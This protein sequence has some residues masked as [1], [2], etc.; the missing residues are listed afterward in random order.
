VRATSRDGILRSDVKANEVNIGD[1]FHRDVRFVAPLYQRPYVWTHEKNWLPMWDAIRLVADRQGREG[2]RDAQARPYFLGAIV[3]EPLNLPTARVTSWQLIDGQ[4]RLTTLQIALAKWSELCK[5]RGFEDL[6][7]L[8]R[9]LTRNRLLSTQDLGEELKVWPTNRD[10]STYSAI[11]RGEAADV[12]T[13]GQNRLLLEAGEFFK[14]QLRDWL[15]DTEGDERRNFEDLLTAL[16][17]WL[18]LV[19]IRLEP[20]DDPQQIFETLNSLGTPLL[21]ADLVKNLL[22]RGMSDTE[23]EALYEKTWRHFEDKALFWRDRVRQGRL[24]TPRIDLFLQHYLV[25]HLQRDVPATELF[26]EFRRYFESGNKTQAQELRELTEYAEIFERIERM[27]RRQPTSKLGA[28]LRRLHRLDTTTVYPLLLEIF[29]RMSDA[30]PTESVLILESYLVRRAV[31]RLTSKN[32]NRLFVQILRDLAETWTP[33]HLRQLLLGFQDETSRWPSD[34]E[35]VASWI[36]VEAYRTLRSGRLLAIFE[37]LEREARSLKNEEIAVEGELS[38]EHLMPQTWTE[39]AW[40][41]PA[42]LEPNEATARR[43]RLVHNIGNLAVLTGKL[44]SEQ[45][46]HPWSKKRPILLKHSVSVLNNALPPEWSDSLI[47]ARSAELAEL[48]K[49]AWPRPATP[50][51]VEWRAGQPPVGGADEEEE[52]DSRGATYKRFFQRV[53]AEFR[54]V[55]PNAN[56]S[57]G[58][59][60]WSWFSF[61]SAATSESHSRYSWSFAAGKRLRSEL[62]IDAKTKAMAKKI[63]DRLAVKRAEIEDAYGGDLSWERLDA[64]K[65][66]RIADYREGN[67]YDEPGVT[68]ELVDWA[69][70]AMVSLYDAVEPRLN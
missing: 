15:A 65:A 23:T 63:F 64:G 33:D 70:T 44:N 21:N 17:R 54:S 58:S 46:N 66:S 8:Y 39:S 24:L 11:I 52:S 49:R 68:D 27:P 6:A 59:A 1:L 35:F 3:L 4:Q 16:K 12:P 41:L 22:L 31:C 36:S 29:R 51:D 32:Y 28:A 38:I 67:V 56:T 13:E 7:S 42:G 62:Y 53:F 48:A 55:R 57:T 2:N 19:E 37:A 9:E 69:V 43:K 25:A 61:P 5:E 26:A 20:D 60:G 50:H 18:V 40:P 34:D 14:N 10:R 47:R 45:S 30:E